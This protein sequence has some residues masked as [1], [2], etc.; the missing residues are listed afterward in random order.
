[1]SDATCSD[2]SLI[3]DLG[4]IYSRRIT[5]MN[6]KRRW[7][8]TKF[9]NIKIGQFPPA[10]NMKDERRHFHAF[11][12]LSQL[13]NFHS[14]LNFLGVIDIQIGDKMNSLLETPKQVAVRVGLSIGAINR[15]MNDG[16]LSFVRIGTRI[17]IP[18]GAWEDYI[19][20][21]TVKPWRDA[22]TDQNSH[23]LKGASPSIFFGQSEAAAASAA[24]ARQTANRLKLLS[25]N[26]SSAT[27]KNSAHVSRQKS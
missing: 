24:L 17:R 16:K 1:M 18:P 3:S 2:F 13:H 22:I 20:T 6:Q 11:S 8:I 9:S 26:S 5:F 19:A 10:L 14:G 15:L 23:I 4:S 12:R 21:H 27:L 25:R 7:V